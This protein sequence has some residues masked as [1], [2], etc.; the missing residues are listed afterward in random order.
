MGE[1]TLPLRPLT[2]GELL[3]AGISVLRRDALRLLGLAAAL[4][5]AEQLLLLPVRS[6]VRLTPPQY[7]PDW[8]AGLGGFWIVLAL[9]LGTEAVA[10]TLLGA[11]AARS[12][13][14]ALLGDEGTDAPR[15]GA[16]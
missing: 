1:A 2:V 14:P 4:A 12:A 11:V 7:I 13:V 5:V 15:P 16:R 10:L 3:D 8:W 9:G 6:S